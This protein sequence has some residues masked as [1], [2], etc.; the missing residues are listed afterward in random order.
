MRRIGA[1]LRTHWFFA[2]VLAVG[3]TG[4]ALT[5]VAYQPAL[6][7][8]DSFRYLANT[9]P[10][11]PTGVDPVGY[12]LVL[13]LL[14][15]HADSLMLVVAIQHLLGLAMGVCIYLL[16][17]RHRMPKTLA[18]LASAP[19]LLDAYEW[20]IEQNILSDSLF[21]ALIT[22]ALV[23]LTWRRRPGPWLAASAGLLLGAAVTVRFV[24]EAT[25]VPAVLFV[26]IAAGPTWRRR[27]KVAAA[28]AV[29]CAMPLVSYAVY[30]HD[31][32]GTYSLQTSNTG[33]LYGRAA[34][35]A[36]CASLPADLKPLCPSGSVA[37][38]DSL[39]PDFYTSTSG[40]PYFASGDEQQAN[41]FSH[42][43][44]KH[45][46]LAFAEAVG[47]DFLQLFLSP[48][49]DV[50]DGTAVSRWQFQTTYPQFPPPLSVTTELATYGHT[51]PSVNVGVAQVLRD[52]QLGGGYTPDAAYAVFLLAGLGG[53]LGLT[54]S[55][56]RSGLRAWCALWTGTGVI[57]LLAADVF[58]FSWRYQLPALIT[59]PIGGAYGIAAL[60]GFGKMWPPM[61]TY[62][63]PADDAA[64]AQFREQY[65]ADFKLPA[66]VVLIAAYN[67]AE[68]IGK[69]IDDLPDERLGLAVK[70][71][72]V[73]DGA[74]DDTAR[75]SL[76]HGAPTCVLP[77]N[78]GQG[79]ALRV[80]YH[81]AYEAGAQYIVTSDADGQYSADELPDLL[82]PIL[83]GSADLTIGSRVLGKRENRDLVRHAG[84][85]LFGA[86]VTFLTRTK[87]TD[88]S[89]GYRAMRAQ[90]PVNIT[91]T[92]AQYQTSEF[93]IG[94]LA[95]GY[96]VADVPVTMH[97]RGHGTTKKGNNLVF[98][99]RYTRVVLGTW[100]REWMWGRRRRA[101]ARS[102][103]GSLSK[104][105]L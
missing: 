82:K 62:P 85:L 50:N 60:L 73:V 76:E 83:D 23:L 103:N 32:T 24:G 100:C 67:E 91:L 18:V 90:V 20:Q 51:A 10:L 16:L 14:L 56:R 86:L 30:E 25:L 72:I 21:L 71:L 95:K 38:R 65:G 53:A 87:V 33:M 3:A 6:L 98:G 63:Q 74:T 43:V 9:G 68:T 26:V 2:L 5:M 1:V 77:T 28:F 105:V 45:Q 36:D 70:P 37:Y 4:R 19:V 97:L 88:T 84:V 64:V 34:T 104:D 94:A 101:G 40:S 39:G 15:L 13:R 49:D 48:H 59:L 12:S 47:H 81:L 54:R 69:V 27:I 22:A 96:R 57:L 46:P 61:R 102:A 7:Y 31:F 79:A 55:A 42:Y 58:L 52:Y 78:R 99:T 75:V 41:P 29:M 66:V 17:L 44:I 35:I 11:N 93:L 89:S 80:G 92:Q 8:T